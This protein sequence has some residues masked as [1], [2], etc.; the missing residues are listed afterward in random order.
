MDRRTALRKSGTLIAAAT[1]SQWLAA[2]AVAQ[3]GFPTR[4]LRVVVPYPPGGATDA[5]A[6]LI[7]EHL[8]K[9][10]GQAVV[11]DNRSGAS[12]AIG[13][14]EVAK[15]P[16]DGHTLLYTLND[17]LINN[18]VL[19]KNL[20]YDP[21]RDFRFVASI[22]RSPALLSVPS[23]LGVRN[24]SEFR[25]FATATGRQLSY[26]TWGLGSLGHLAAETLARQLKFN[27]VHIPQ[28]GEA[29]VLQ[30]LLS[31]TIHSGWTSAGT[32]RQHVQSGRL[33]PLAMMG[34]ERST[35]LPEVPTFR[36]LGITDTFFDRSV[37][38][39]FLVP[40][41]T[42]NDVVARLSIDIQAIAQSQEVLA[43]IRERGLEPQIA[44][45][46][47][48]TAQYSEEFPVITQRLRALGI[49]PS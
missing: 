5:T 45:A 24:F 22:L 46:D 21:Q 12:G 33:V 34:R 29:P 42:P 40:A 16:A 9:R 47:A 14:A 31:N 27:A 2:P 36:E 15:A 10:L 23:S 39:A 17:P 28:R 18:T 44:G 7:S 25:S 49:E 4:S 32:A 37:W 11:V 3:P 35:A 48:A 38:M 30:D 19:V 20:A 13:C 41:R 1:T 8:A 43:A 26:G 6:R